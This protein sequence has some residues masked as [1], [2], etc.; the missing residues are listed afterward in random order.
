VAATETDP[1]LVVVVPTRRRPHNIRSL[2][3]AF[4]ATT[5]HPD[6]TVEIV[7][8]GADE[9]T[10]DAYFDA[11]ACEPECTGD[12]CPNSWIS[13]CTQ[14]HRGMCATLNYIAAVPEFGAMTYSTIVGFMGDDHRPRTVGWDQAI[15]DAMPP[16][17]VVYCDDGFQGPNLPTSVFMDAELIR[18]LGWMVPP[19]I[20]HL[21]CDNAWKALGEALGTLVYLPDV[22]IEHMHPH[23]DKAPMDQGYAEVNSARQWEADEAAFRRWVAADLP[24]DIARVKGAG[25]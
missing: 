1:R 2:I 15:I 14:S 19:G 9:A 11:W 12:G 23:A 18:R 7:V 16:L 24:R 20:G 3:E 17:G 25:R 10:A 5:R 22:L 4:A 21:F 13:L 6:T 8:D